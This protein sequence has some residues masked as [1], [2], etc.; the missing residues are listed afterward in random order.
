MASFIT[1]LFRGPD[2]PD[3]TPAPAP[4]KREDT[5]E[6]GRKSRKK[7]A[8]RRGRRSTILSGEGSSGATPIRKQLLGG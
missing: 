7:A 3:V 5:A 6:A 2:L 8:K 1:N 4:A